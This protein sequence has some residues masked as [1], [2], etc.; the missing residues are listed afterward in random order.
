MKIKNNPSASIIFILLIIV[1]CSSC[2]STYQPIQLSQLSFEKTDQIR[3]LEEIDISWKY[4]LLTESGNELYASNETD[5]LFTKRSLLAIRIQNKGN[6][7][8]IFPEEVQIFSGNK[9]LKPL[10]SRKAFHLLKM[11]NNEESDNAIEDIYQG[12]LSMNSWASNK[13]FK[14]DLQSYYLESR[15][16]LPGETV[17]G[18]LAL[19]V[20]PGTALKFVTNKK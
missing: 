17:V 13:E 7:P 5:A 2:I 18:L 3:K 12:I 6:E 4:N 15:Q 1:L 9:L 11:D 8:L 19:K 16:I 20:E 10:S 14:K